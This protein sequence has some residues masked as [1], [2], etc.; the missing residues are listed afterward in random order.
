MGMASARTKE[1]DAWPNV[2]PLSKLSSGQSRKE[3]AQI[4]LQPRSPVHKSVGLEVLRV[5][6]KLHEEIFDVNT[7]AQ[8]GADKET[9]QD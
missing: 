9:K 4:N 6:W 2:Q 3:L 8:T 7:E 5:A 1:M